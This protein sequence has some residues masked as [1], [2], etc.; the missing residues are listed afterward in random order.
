MCLRTYS[1]QSL[2]SSLFSGPWDDYSPSPHASQLLC[3]ALRIL[4]VM[5]G[6]FS[7]VTMIAT[8]HPFATA[9][10]GCLAILALRIFVYEDGTIAPL[11]RERIQLPRRDRINQVIIPILP[12]TPSVS[13]AYGQHHFSRSASP[14]HMS[15]SPPVQYHYQDLPSPTQRAQLGRREPHRELH[16][17]YSHLGE[18]R[19]MSLQALQLPHSH[20]ANAHAPL[21]RA[22]SQHSQ[23]YDDQRLH[24]DPT[25]RAILGE[26]SWQN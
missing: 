6:T 16:H 3:T 10:T 24:R 1:F 19:G 13:Y 12:Q 23:R 4:T 2:S 17:A 15:Y 18:R 21:A 26:R 22:H 5:V 20:V 9:L 25:Q 14:I 7:L 8:G 11:I